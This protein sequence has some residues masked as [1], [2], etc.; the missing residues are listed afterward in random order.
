EEYHPEKRGDEEPNFNNA[1]W[2]YSCDKASIYYQ[3]NSILR[4]ENFELL[5]SYRYYLSD[6]CRMI[7]VIFNNTKKTNQ[8][9]TTLYRADKINKL[10]FEKMKQK[11]KGQLITMNGFVSTTTDIGI[12]EGYARNQFV[13]P[14]A[15]S[16][17]FEIKYNP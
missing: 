16:V 17:L 12:A 14:G 15:V 2:W 10:S 4:L 1:I 5:M 7:E 11:Q 9:G 3:I 8:K 13:P 6:L